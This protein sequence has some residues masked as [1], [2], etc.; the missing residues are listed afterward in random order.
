MWLQT[1]FSH[2]LLSFLLLVLAGCGFQPRGESARLA[3]SLSPIVIAGLPQHNPFYRVLAEELNN[4]GATLGQKDAA[5]TRIHILRQK[6][7]RLVLSVDERGKTVEYELM[8]SVQYRITHPLN[9]PAMEPRQLVSR[10]I[11]FNPGTQLL[12][13]NREETMLRKDMHHELSRQLINHLSTI[14]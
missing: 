3:A 6:P 11:L 13:R 5:A 7:E 4:A 2:I 14:K 8:E 10:R 9:S 1:R 12:G